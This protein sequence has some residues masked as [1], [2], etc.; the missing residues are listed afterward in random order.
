M[1][2]R[3]GWPSVDA[4]ADG[5]FLGVWS[6]GAACLL[7]WR[8]GP[9]GP[10]WIALRWRPASDPRNATLGPTERR[11]RRSGSESMVVRHRPIADLT[12]G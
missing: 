5:P 3:P 1:T 11:F 9:E 2:W 4:H 8:D 10:E 7:E 12:V 6:D